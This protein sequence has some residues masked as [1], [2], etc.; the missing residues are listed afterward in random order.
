MN[1]RSLAYLPRCSVSELVKSAQ[2]VLSRALTTLD[3]NPSFVDDSFINLNGKS[4]I[5]TGY[6]M[7]SVDL[8][9]LFQL[10]Q[11]GFSRTPYVINKLI[12]L[13]AKVG[14]LGAGIQLH[15]AV[16]KMG[17]FSNVY[18]SSALVGVYVKCANVTSAKQLFDE[19]PHRNVVTW[20]SLISG[21]LKI[22]CPEIA[23]GLF[24]EMLRVGIMPTAYGVSAILLGCA[25][26]EAGELG[27]QI[28]GLSF[29]CGFC[30]NVVAG[31]SLV[32]MYAKC[33]KVKESR[34]VFDRMPERNV[35]TWTTMLTGYAQ[36]KLPIDAMIL[37]REMWQIGLELNR[38]TYN[39]LLS[40]FSGR[41]HLDHCK[42]I[43]SHII[44]EGLESNLFIQATLLSVYSECDCS[45][46]TSTRS[47]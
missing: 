10:Q 42:Q 25:Q 5:D 16:V 3:P 15:C 36:N 22:F 8:N 12:S 21:Y 6:N 17:F 24:L 4:S 40:S 23:L 19:M 34:R 43:H 29:K 37:F 46:K 35:V 9:L 30:S 20:N 41:D 11:Y 31:T 39:S 38:V 13:C 14:D 32:N 1:A 28:H 2:H 18:I 7:E 45:L 27:T 47:S 44:R 26:L 33:T